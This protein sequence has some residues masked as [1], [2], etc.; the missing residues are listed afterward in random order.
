VCIYLEWPYTRLRAKLAVCLA[1][2]LRLCNVVQKPVML[3]LGLVRPNFVVLVLA[4]S[5][6]GLGLDLCGLV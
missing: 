1:S 5:G 4:L 3:S 6:L 2:A